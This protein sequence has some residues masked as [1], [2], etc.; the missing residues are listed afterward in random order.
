M[1]K[2][3]SSTPSAAN[4]SEPMLGQAAIAATTA[5]P[6]TNFQLFGSTVLVPVASMATAIAPAAMAAADNGGHGS[7]SASQNASGSD[8]FSCNG[9]GLV[10]DAVRRKHLRADGRASRRRHHHRCHADDKLLALRIHGAG[11]GGVHGDGYC[12]GSCGSSR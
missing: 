3:S 4:T 10:V 6:M 1:E 2:G 7:S 9:E 8:L 5:V 11:S 12:S